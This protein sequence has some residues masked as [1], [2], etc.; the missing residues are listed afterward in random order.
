MPGKVCVVYIMTNRSN[1]VL[2]TGVTSN[3][4]KRVWEHKNGVISSSFTCRYRVHK[5]VWFE[6]T[7]NIMAAIQR[8]KEIKGDSRKNKLSLINRMNPEWKDLAIEILGFKE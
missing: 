1:S 8:E 5:L 3:L 6:T 2:Y 7:S 4:P